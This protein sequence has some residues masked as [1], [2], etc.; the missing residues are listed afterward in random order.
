MNLAMIYSALNDVGAPITQVFPATEN[1]EGG[2]LVDGTWLIQLAKNQEEP[3]LLDEIC[4]NG[5]I[6]VASSF[7]SVD[8]LLQFIMEN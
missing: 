1:T 4:L 3:I 8:D 7:R 6:N 2:I 5:M